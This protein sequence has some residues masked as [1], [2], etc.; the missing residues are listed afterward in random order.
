L[1]V[2]FGAQFFVWLTACGTIGFDQNKKDDESSLDLGLDTDDE[3]RVKIEGLSPDWA[4]LAGGTEVTVTGRGFEGDVE[5][6]FG[7]TEVD[8][9]VLDPQTIVVDSPEVFSAT[10]VDVWVIS[11]W[12]EFTLED[13]FSFGSSDPDPGDTDTDTDS[14]GSG[15]SGVTL[16]FDRIAYGCPACFGLTDTY[17]VAA[18][19]Y[20]YE[21]TSGSWDS[22]MPAI[23]SCDVDPVQTTLGSSYDDMGGH[24]Y[25]E[26]GSAISIDLS[27]QTDATGSWYMNSALDTDD[28]VKNASFDLSVPD[29][30]AE[31]PFTVTG[32]LVTTSGFD[33]FSP[34]EILYDDTLAF[35]P[36]SSSGFDFTWSPTGVGDS[37]VVEVYVFNAG[38]VQI[39]SVICVDYDS[40]SMSIPATM[41]SGFPT[42][43][44]L[45]IV[46][47]RSVTQTSTHPGNGSII[48]AY[49]SFGVVGTATLLQ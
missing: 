45:G 7:G 15:L 17:Q 3:L 37:V 16:G 14:S 25:L 46:V 31:G 27:R 8:V 49:S 22:W 4:P 28:Y 48:E 13:G 47:Y 9:T 35:Q 41:F 30:G 43:S 21:P 18:L 40:G 26:S 36:M 39:G 44:L 29:G 5:F 24:V 1:S 19:A 23:G 2:L 38:G 20:F 6:G 32:A 33:D 42:G 12:G 10:T 11:D 34:L